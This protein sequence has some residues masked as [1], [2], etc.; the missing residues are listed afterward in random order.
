MSAIL[1][2]LQFILTP[3]TNAM[4]YDAGYFYPGPSIEGATLDLAPQESQDIIAQFGRDWYDDLIEEMPK[5]TPLPPADMVL[6]F[7]IWDRE[8]GSGK[9]EEG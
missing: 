3:E 2:L 1:N 9:Y 4:A 7:D 6:A 5:T 8:I